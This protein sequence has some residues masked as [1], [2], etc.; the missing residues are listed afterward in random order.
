MNLNSVN[1]LVAAHSATPELEGK[2]ARREAE[3]AIVRRMFVWLSWGMIVL[4]LG[5]LMLVLK[6]SLDLGTSFGLAASLILLAGVAMASIGVLRAMLQGVN[7]SDK[8]ESKVLK[9]SAP[10]TYLPEERIP[11]STPS[12]TE[13]TTRILDSSQKKEGQ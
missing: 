1:Q 2:V 13:R 10:T 12:V 7:P 11:I 5:V 8:K 3:R 6:K 9:Q 4:G